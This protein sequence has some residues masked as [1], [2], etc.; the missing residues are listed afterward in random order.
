MNFNPMTWMIRHG[1]APNL[2]MI[3]LIFGG[4]VMSFMIRKEYMPETT[5]DR[6][7]VR[8]SYPGASPSE[9]EA[10]ISAPIEDMLTN[11]QGIR[12]IDS[13][14]YTGGFVLPVNWKQTRMHN[15]FIKT[16]NKR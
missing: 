13:N 12:R 9:M 5:L 2:L 8:V 14:I 1:I 4:L 15:K 6:I 11:L 7:S 3:A 16:L 10:S